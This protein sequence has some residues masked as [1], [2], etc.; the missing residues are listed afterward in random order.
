MLINQLGIIYGVKCRKKIQFEIPLRYNTKKI[1]KNSNNDNKIIILLWKI[2][3]TI[4]MKIQQQQ[5]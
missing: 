1:T 4:I 5:Q 3:L 2:L